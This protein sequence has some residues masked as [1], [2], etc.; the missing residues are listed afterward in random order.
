VD[1]LGRGLVVEA[2]AD[3][4]LVE[5]FRVAD[6]RAFA[7]GV[8]WHPEWKVMENEDSLAIFR[9][10]GDAARRYAEEKGHG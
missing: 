4:G 2:V 6:A 10:F 8:Q 7:L 9:R 3:D 1:R 5:A